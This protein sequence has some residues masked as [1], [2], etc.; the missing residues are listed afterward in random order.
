MLS[1]QSGGLYGGGPTWWD[2][3][4]GGMFPWE[5]AYENPD[6]EASILNKN[7][8]VRADGH[9]FFEPLG[10]NR[11]A[12]ITCHQ[13]SDG[14]SLSTGTLRER[15]KTTD[16]RDPVFAAIDGSNCPDLPQRSEKS[17]SLLLDRG[18]IRIA[19]AWPPQGAKPEFQIEVVRD[20]TGCN[21]SATY[22]LKSGTPAI[23]VYRR[24]R[25]AANLAYVVDGE[26]SNLMADGREPSL[27]SQAIDAA[28]THE[29]AGSRPSAQQ[30]RQIEDFEMQVFAAQSADVR[31]GLVAEK[32]GPLLGTGN[33]AGGETRSLGDDAAGRVVLSFKLWRKQ[34][35]DGDLGVQREFRASAARGSEVFFT[36]RFQVGGA[37]ATCATCHGAGVR[38]PMDIG[39][40]NVAREQA[41][42]DLPLFRIV[43][44]ASAAPHPALGRVFYTQDPGRALITGK[45]ADAGAIVPQQL[46][47][48][49]ARAP[50]FSNGSAKTLRDV[51]DF[52]DLRFGIGYSEQEKRDLT[53]FL[54]V[55]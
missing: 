1:A 54:R 52:Y 9:A 2:A 24:P 14:M 5:E 11:R 45:C 26:D 27:R 15:W 40:T 53:N 18:L 47:A 29:Q 49:P 6:G 44:D 23:S 50:Y 43:C 31:G 39:T 30:L 10:A 7:G 33:L 46:R 8:A 48:L 38:K 35:G 55:L 28:L 36:R 12:C 34:P 32:S 19:L 42:P 16:G 51:V 22:G 37:A 20:P 21:L 25:M 17:H 3:S 41:W 13:P 4:R